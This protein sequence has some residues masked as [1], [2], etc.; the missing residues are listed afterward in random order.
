MRFKC[1]SCGI[2]FDDIG[3]LASHK[4]QH[5]S[6][7]QESS[8]PKGITCLNCA[9]KI[10]LDPSQYNY[11]GPLTCPIC[12]RNMKVTLRDGEVVVARTG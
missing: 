8:G 5:Q 1:N 3:Q 6:A 9:K 2:E 4:R 11:S 12:H 7:Q 10:T